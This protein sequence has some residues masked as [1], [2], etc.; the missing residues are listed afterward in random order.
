MHLFALLFR[1]QM[2]YKIGELSICVRVSVLEPSVALFFTLC[3]HSIQFQRMLLASVLIF[4]LRGHQEEN[5]PI[6][7]DTTAR[8]NLQE[9]KCSSIAIAYFKSPEAFGAEGIY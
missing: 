9:T 3:T 5:I 2:F 4:L 1:S 8:Y 6:I 7:Q